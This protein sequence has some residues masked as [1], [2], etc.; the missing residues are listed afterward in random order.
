MERLIGGMR[1][2][3]AERI[4]NSCKEEGKEKETFTKELRHQQ[5]AVARV[6]QVWF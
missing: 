4:L 5:I 2:L 6:V 3:V 1:N